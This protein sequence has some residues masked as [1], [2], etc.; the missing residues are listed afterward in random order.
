MRDSLSSQF[1]IAAALIG[2][3][4]CLHLTERHEQ[5]VSIKPL[6]T[7]IDTFTTNTISTSM[8]RERLWASPI[9]ILIV[10]KEWFTFITI[11]QTYIIGTPTKS[12]TWRGAIQVKQ[13]K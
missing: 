10:T 9:A 7:I 3:S 13:W 5:S 8:M 4:V 12:P 11:I 2:I 1:V 6:I